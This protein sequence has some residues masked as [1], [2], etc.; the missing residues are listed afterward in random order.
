MDMNSVSLKPSYSSHGHIGKWTG[1]HLLHSPLSNSSMRWQRRPLICVSLMQ[2]CF[3]SCEIGT[4]RPETPFRLGIP[5]SILSYSLV[6]IDIQV[7]RHLTAFVFQSSPSSA[8]RLQ[9]LP[10]Q[11]RPPQQATTAG[12]QTQYA[13]LI[14][15]FC[16][17]CLQLLLFSTVAST[18]V[19]TSLSCLWRVVASIRL[20]LGLR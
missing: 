3:V 15:V 17:L 9:I 13:W 20:T 2:R 5:G 6:F 14:G 11:R 8:R 12:Q 10:Q 4:W 19:Q 1:T 7:S 16:Y 18:S